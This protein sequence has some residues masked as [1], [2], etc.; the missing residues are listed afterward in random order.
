MR[1]CGA[2][3]P[4]DAKLVA[5]LRRRAKG[6][7]PNVACTV[8]GCT[9]CLMRDAADTIEALRKSWYACKQLATDAITESGEVPLV[10]GRELSSALGFAGY[11]EPSR[12]EAPTSS[13]IEARE[14]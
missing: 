10:D 1:A 4:A 7:C 14:K 3:S 6:Y 5:E 13:M 12:S 9:A 2:A 11:A 8:R